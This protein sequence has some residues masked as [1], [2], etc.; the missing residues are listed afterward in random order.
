MLSEPKKNVMNIAQ[1]VNG[2]L[3][4]L[5]HPPLLEL[6]ADVVSNLVKTYGEVIVSTLVTLKTVAE[7]ITL[8]VSGLEVT[9][10]K[11]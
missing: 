7:L 9:L 6:I 4:L 10:I 2:S 11:L 5:Q 1:F 8:S 3:P